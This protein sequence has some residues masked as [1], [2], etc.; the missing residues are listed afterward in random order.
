[1]LDEGY[2]SKSARFADKGFLAWH[3]GVLS[4]GKKENLPLLET[5]PPPTVAD[6]Y[7]FMR[8]YYKKQWAAYILLRRLLALKNPFRE[9]AAYRKAAKTAKVSMTNSPVQYHEYHGF[10]SPL[11]QSAPRVSVIIPTLN[12]YEYLKDVL[13]DLEK[14]DYKNFEVVIADQTDQPDKNF[15]NAY[16]LDLNLIFQGG[17]GQW[18]ARNECIRQAKGDFLLFFDDDSRI[19]ADWISQHLKALDFFKAD[20]SAGVSISH[21]GDKIP[22]NY[23][24]FRWAD[25]FDS[26]N[27]MVRKNVFSTIGMFDRQFDK[28]RMGD[29]E[30]GLRAYLAG[31]RSISHPYAK[32]LHLKVSSGGLR[33]MGSWDG[34]RPT[35]WFAP[36]PIPSVVY[37][38]RKYYSPM[39]V[40]EAILNGVALSLIPYK[41]KG[42]KK[43]LFFSLFTSF[44][45]LPIVAVQVY[46]SWKK[47]SQMLKEGDKIEWPGQPPKN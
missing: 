33:Q 10:S 32:R 9:I 18:L 31:F 41:H 1:M 38:F 25:Q 15:Y 39:A 4:T 28:M 19:D 45:L 24:Y 5:T 3:K 20:I 14:Q 34:F 46:K 12:R 22:E 35:K 21:V 6:E 7:R 36:R 2:E 37:L 27:A 30:F 29:G 43:M 47:A 17:K 13:E 42:N 23:A 26:G 8:K 16:K 11:L 44:L 40:R